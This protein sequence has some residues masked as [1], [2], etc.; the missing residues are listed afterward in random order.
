MTENAKPMA[1]LLRMLMP[2][3]LP[4][5]FL[6]IGTRTL[7]YK[8]T[9]IKVPIA[10]TETTEPGGIV[11][12]SLSFKFIEAACFTKSV[13]A[14]AKVIPVV[15]EASHMGIMLRTSFVSSTL[16]TVANLHGLCFGLTGVSSNIA[17]LSRNL[18]IISSYIRHYLI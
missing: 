7:S 12:L 8:G 17:A 13:V 5:I 10:V 18:F 16:V 9:N 1:I 15:N 11:K 4:V 6:I 2:L 14:C 3:S